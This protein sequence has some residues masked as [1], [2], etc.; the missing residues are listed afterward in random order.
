MWAQ[1]L[2]LVTGL[3]LLGS[4]FLSVISTASHRWIEKNIDSNNTY[5]LGLW[6][7]C[8]MKQ[9]IMTSRVPFITEDHLFGK[10]KNII[11]LLPVNRSCLILIP[12][13]SFVGFLILYKENSP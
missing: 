12:Q 8:D 10:K 6:K 4:L 3:C 7:F 11:G 2:H 5:H 13:G 1:F 9:C